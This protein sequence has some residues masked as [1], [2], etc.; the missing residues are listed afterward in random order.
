M[1]R[2]PVQSGRQTAVGPA[3]GWVGSKLAALMKPSGDSHL[4]GSEDSLRM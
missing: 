4:G 2:R 3:H 1:A